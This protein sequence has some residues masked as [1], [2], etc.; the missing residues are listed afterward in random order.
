MIRRSTSAVLSSAVSIAI[1]TAPSGYLNHVGNQLL[2]IVTS[3]GNIPV[4]G[5]VLSENASGTRFRDRDLAR[6]RSMHIY[7]DGWGLEASFGRL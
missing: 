2:F 3:T 4:G 5:P 6:T 1:P 7:G